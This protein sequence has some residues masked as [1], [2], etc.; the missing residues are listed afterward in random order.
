MALII[1]EVRK[2]SGITFTKAF[3]LFLKLIL[4]RIIFVTGI[5]WI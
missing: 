4:S 3:D 2:P 5:L 1:S